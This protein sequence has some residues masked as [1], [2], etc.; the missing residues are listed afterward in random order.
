MAT[1][2]DE[3]LGRLDAA[4]AIAERQAKAVMSG[5][6]TLRRQAASGILA[7]LPR[8]LEQLPAATEPRVEALQTASGSFSYDAD[9]AFADGDYL[10]E[11]QAAAKAK[12]LV[13][14]ERDGRIT[15]FPL[16]LRLE[17]AAPETA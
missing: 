4:L 14:V 17:P 16:L 12:G 15:A 3:E 9:A 7:G 1:Q 13:L 8:R 6:R 5:L 2:L 10:R 11:L